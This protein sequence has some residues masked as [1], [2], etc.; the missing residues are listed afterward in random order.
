MTLARVMNLPGRAISASQA[1]NLSSGGALAKLHTLNLSESTFASGALAALLGGDLSALRELR[2]RECGLTR[3]DINALAAWPGLATLHTLD[4]SVNYEAPLAPLFHSP[5]LGVEHLLLGDQA[6]DALAARTLAQNPGAARLT[7][8]SMPSVFVEA[9]ALDALAQSPHLVALERLLLKASNWQTNELAA[10]LDAPQLTALRDVTIIAAEPIPAALAAQIAASPQ[11][12]RLTAFNLPA[13]GAAAAAFAASPQLSPALRHPFAAIVEE[14]TREARRV[15]AALAEARALEARNARISADPNHH[16]GELRSAL[17]AGPS[18]ASWARICERLR[19]WTDGQTLVEMAIPY[20]SQ[21]TEAWPAAVRVSQPWMTREAAQG[22]HALISQLC[23]QVEIADKL[24][25]GMLRQLIAAGAFERVEVLRLRDGANAQ[26]EAA[27]LLVTDRAPRLTELVIEGQLLQDKH[28]RLLKDATGGPPITRLSLANNRL[29]GESLE[30]LGAW[31]GGRRL[32]SLDLSGNAW[33]PRA[34]AAPLDLPALRSLSLAHIQMD[35]AWL[36]WLL[37]SPTLG[38]LRELRL[39]H[40][41]GPG[42]THGGAL[43]ALLYHPVC[44]HLEVFSAEWHSWQPST[45]I[46]ALREINT[47]RGVAWSEAVATWVNGL[48]TRIEHSINE[49][50]YDRGDDGD[51]DDTWE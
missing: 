51:Y 8:L 20:V 49:D 12:A 34:I 6:L 41:N 18:A 9:G 35:E 14:E 15:E 19:T 3:S 39:G 31:Q 50:R 33:T 4:L 29:R 17:Q 42:A 36:R 5:H 2:L 22:H 21:A 1:K 44:A 38:H 7:S 37:R 40:V 11:L 10:L 32:E 28:L 30:L 46:A 16:F 26:Q 13:R 23:A 45:E 48:I 47:R 25:P 24:K 27:E 43:A